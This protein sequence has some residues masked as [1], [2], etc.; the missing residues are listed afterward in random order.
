MS[1][2]F[3]V[4]VVTLVPEMWPL[5]LG[6]GGGLVGRAF[7]GGPATLTVSDLRD[8]GR[9]PHRQVDDSPFGGGAGMVLAAPPLHAAI[10]RA[11]IRTPGPI[12]LMTPRGEP[13]RQN[14]VHDLAQGHGMTLV[15]GRY[16]GFDDRIRKYVDLELSAGDFVL[17][18]G[19]FA[20][21]NLIDAVVRLL[22]G[23]LGN[24]QSLLE[25]SFGANLLEYPQYT[26]PAEYEGD[27]V[28]PVLRSGDHQRVAAWRCQ[29]ALA[30]T[31]SMRP[32][33]LMRP[34]HEEK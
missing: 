16:E 30:V 27:E 15:C 24:R 6:P 20:A 23:V 19:D 11:R 26:R 1:S 4:E 7:A 3:S 14:R 8:F 34:S 33:L 17:S 9:G 5:W 21:L 12:I 28:P 31:R 18:A 10:Q 2:P 32:D 22:P 25:E 13:L 29:Q